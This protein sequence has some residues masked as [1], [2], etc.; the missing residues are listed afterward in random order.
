MRR[1]LRAANPAEQGPVASILPE[2]ESV[3][4]L[5]MRL[6]EER[7]IETRPGLHCAPAAHRFLGSFPDGAVRVSI[8]PW[9]TARELETLLG[10]LS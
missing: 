2:G 1:L 8:G 9:T 5:A 10:A 7:G 3:S 4:A 6:L